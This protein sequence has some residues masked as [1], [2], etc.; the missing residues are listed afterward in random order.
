MVKGAAELATAT[1]GFSVVVSTEARMEALAPTLIVGILA[2]CAM[3]M[4][5]AMPPLVPVTRALMV[6]GVVE[7]TPVVWAG[8]PG[9]APRHR[10]RG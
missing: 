10:G 1:V 3:I 8:H 4:A 5:L 2:F 9:A 6:P 7:P